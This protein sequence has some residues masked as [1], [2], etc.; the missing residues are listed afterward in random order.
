MVAPN[1]YSK[2]EKQKRNRGK[3]LFPKGGGDKSIREFAYLNEC[4]IEKKVGGKKDQQSLRG[5]TILERDDQ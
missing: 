4:T 5:R 2:T 1:L 3:T